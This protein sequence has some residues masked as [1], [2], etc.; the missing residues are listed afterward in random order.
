[1][2]NF[3]LFLLFCLSHGSINLSSCLKDL[4]YQEVL[5]E[6]LHRDRDNMEL[7]YVV[8]WD[9]FVVGCVQDLS[10]DVETM[11]WAKFEIIH[12]FVI[13]L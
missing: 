1:M 7:A 13:G 2:A 8:F 11:V 9:L 12:D 10:D 5:V 3:L 6:V 4:M